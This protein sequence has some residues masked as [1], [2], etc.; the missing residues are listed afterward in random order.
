MKLILAG[1]CGVGKS[2]IAKLIEAQF[3]NVKYLDLDTIRGQRNEEYK[4][5]LSPCSLRY[6]D[7]KKCLEPMLDLYSK[8]FILDIGGDTVF[9]HNVNNEERIA[10]ISRIK[11]NY[12]ASVIVLVADKDVLCQ[13]FQSSEKKGTVDKFEQVWEDWQTIG[14]PNWKRCEDCRVDTTSFVLTENELPKEFVRLLNSYL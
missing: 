1:P 3:E 13:R 6:L 12:S 11:K 10:Q 4:N 2:R 7:L 5:Q 9:R 14:E 8:G